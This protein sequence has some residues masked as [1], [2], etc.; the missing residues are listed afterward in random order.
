MIESFPMYKI[1]NCIDCA[2]TTKKSLFEEIKT[3]LLTHRQ[4]IWYG[5][6][7]HIVFFM[8]DP[9]YSNSFTSDMSYSSEKDIFVYG[10]K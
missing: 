9:P 10:V 2:I 1:N 4:I 5:Q 7:A 3:V 8:G 6:I